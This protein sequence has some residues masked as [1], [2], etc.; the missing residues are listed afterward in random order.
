MSHLEDVAVRTGPDTCARCRKTLV[1][2]D[3]LTEVKLVAG[4][5][6]HPRGYGE[7]LYVSEAEEYAHVVC[8][9][10]SLDGPF[11][12]LARSLLKVSTEIESISARVPDFMC[13][14]CK[15][16]F[17]RSD[18]VVPAIIVEGIGKDPDTGMKGV[19]C[20]PEFEMV[21]YDCRDPKLGGT[22]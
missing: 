16:R 14:R 21:H 7:A 15:K 11:I 6:P 22:P 3:R 1:R 8:D 19:Q 13:A 10:R 18:R 12:D 20:S 17:E 4:V 9:N 2:H 5:G